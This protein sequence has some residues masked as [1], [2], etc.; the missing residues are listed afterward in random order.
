VLRGHDDDP[1]GGFIMATSASRTG[2]T[3]PASARGPSAA[4]YG[5]AALLA[6]LGIVGAVLWQKAATASVDRHA[7]GY[8]RTATPGAVTLRVSDPGTYYVYAEGVEGATLSDLAVK[9]TGPTGQVV[10]VTAVSSRFYY[11]HHGMVGH[12]VGRFEATRL[13][14]YRVTAAGRLDRYGHFAVG[15]DVEGRML[16]H[17]WGAGVLLVFAVGSGITFTVVTFLQRRARRRA[18]AVTASP[19][20]AASGNWRVARGRGN[21]MSPVGRHVMKTKTDVRVESTAQAL[22]P[23]DQEYLLTL[24][25]LYHVDVWDESVTKEELVAMIAEAAWN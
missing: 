8:A 5:F 4:R 19:S 13:G 23:F 22:A 6:V 15:D 18:S 14:G 11:D 10:A 1:N 3:S 20:A 16:P 7:G 17:L 2:A 12:A 25:R 9:V 21:R 24:A